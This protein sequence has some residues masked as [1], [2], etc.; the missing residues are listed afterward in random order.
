MA[1]TFATLDLG[2]QD[3]TQ[4]EPPSDEEI[5]TTGPEELSRHV[6]WTQQ[7]VQEIKHDEN[8]AL[9]KL[10]AVV[11]EGKRAH[12]IVMVDKNSRVWRRQ[13]WV[14]LNSG[15]SN[16]VIACAIQESQSEP[17][18][19]VSSM[20]IIGDYPFLAENQQVSMKDYLAS[21][22]LGLGCAGSKDKDEEFMSALVQ[23]VEML[24]VHFQQG[25][26]NDSRD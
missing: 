14:G 21:L 22:G 11:W 8:N 20:L 16:R 23:R 10:G 17:M 6:R 7:L 18:G 15:G 25:G 24:P 13:A 1:A 19:S 3:G 4:W 9:A 5:Y 12:Q 26:S 2:T